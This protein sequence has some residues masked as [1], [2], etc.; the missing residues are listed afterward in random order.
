MAFDPGSYRAGPPPVRREPKASERPF[1]EVLDRWLAGG[2]W[3]AGRDG[4]GSVRVDDGTPTGRSRVRN[5]WA[6]ELKVR[7]WTG[8]DVAT[9]FA[10]EDGET[11]FYWWA[12]GKTRT[13]VD[14]TP[15]SVTSDE[16][17]AP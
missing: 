5:R 1:R 4:A 9:R 10:T 14:T 12:V 8:R 11:R 15:R 6:Y 3:D 7:G 13:S 16:E 2:G 17:N